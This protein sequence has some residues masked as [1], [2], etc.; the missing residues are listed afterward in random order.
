MVGGE[1]GEGEGPACDG[2]GGVAVGEPALDGAA[3]VGDAGGRRHRVL[4]R[5]QRDR[6]HEMMRRHAIAATRRLHVY[7]SEQVNAL[8]H[9]QVAAI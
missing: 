1:V 3:V 2:A 9:G 6:A 8:A 7:A 5:L 4:H